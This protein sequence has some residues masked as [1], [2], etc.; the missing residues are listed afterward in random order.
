LTEIQYFRPLV[1]ICHEWDQNWI[2]E[3]TFLKYEQTRKTWKSFYSC[4]N[5]ETLVKLTKRTQRMSISLFHLCEFLFFNQIIKVQLCIMK[6]NNFNQK[7]LW[8]WNLFCFGSWCIQSLLFISQ[9]F[10]VLLTCMLEGESQ[11]SAVS[12]QCILVFCLVWGFG[13]TMTGIV[14][15]N[16]PFFTSIQFMNF[17]VL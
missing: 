14:W 9:S 3:R 2:L 11:V 12:L 10:S 7:C 17:P 6:Q 8:I 5:E 4:H 1:C 15:V 13:A 16:N